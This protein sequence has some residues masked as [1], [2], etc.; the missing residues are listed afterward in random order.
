MHEH[1][2]EAVSLRIRRAQKQRAGVVKNRRVFLGETAVD[3]KGAR[4]EKY[5]AFAEVL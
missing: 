1:I 5:V 4:M 3:S 2:G